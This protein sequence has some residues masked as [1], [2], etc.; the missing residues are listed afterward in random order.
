LLFGV[1]S[2]A[3][4]TP[5]SGTSLYAADCASCHGRYAD[6]TGPASADIAVPD[7]R[8][9]AADNGGVFPRTEVSNVIDGRSPVKAHL[10]RQMPVWG[11]TFAS[12]ERS[13]KSAE[14]PVRAKI[15]A[16]VDYLAAIQQRR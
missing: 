10:A 11:D 5:P 13:N 15:D 7:L 3:T 8:Y 2:C 1:A 9:L 16:L 12:M 4:Q 14:A 6:G